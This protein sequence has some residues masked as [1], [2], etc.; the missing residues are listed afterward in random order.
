MG[1]AAERESESSNQCQQQDPPAHAQATR[2]TESENQQ[3]A[4]AANTIQVVRFKFFSMPM[5]TEYTIREESGGDYNSKKASLSQSTITR[6]I[7]TSEELGQEV[8]NEIIN[9]FG[10]KLKQS[11]GN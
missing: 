8:K 3:A 4:E 6:L 5:G 11:R 1:H 2:D 9:E 10:R 7:N